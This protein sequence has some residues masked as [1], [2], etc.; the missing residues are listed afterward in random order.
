MSDISTA[1]V[2]WQAIA[3]QHLRQGDIGKVAVL[4]QKHRAGGLVHRPGVAEGF[5]YLL[6]GKAA[7]AED[8]ALFVGRQ[9]VGNIVQQGSY[10]KAEP[11]SFGKGEKGRKKGAFLLHR[12]GMGGA[13]GVFSFFDLLP[14]R[15]K[16]GILAEQS[17]FPDDAR[18]ARRQKTVGAFLPLCFLPNLPG[19]DFKGGKGEKN[20]VFTVLFLIKAFFS[21]S[22]RVIFSSCSR[23]ASTGVDRAKISSG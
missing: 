21:R 3:A 12:K 4:F 8:S 6:F 23:L 22:A 14:E 17:L 18:N 11:L 9:P 1:P 2:V 5:R 10:A 13:A 15:R 20:A 16:D 7:P 19:G